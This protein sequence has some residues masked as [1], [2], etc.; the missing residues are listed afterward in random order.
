[1]DYYVKV[2]NLPVGDSA[3]ILSDNVPA[4]SFV[5][6]SS[7]RNAKSMYFAGYLQIVYLRKKVPAEFAKTL[8]PNRRNEVIQNYIKLTFDVPVSIYPNGN[9]YSGLDLMVAGYWAWS[10]KISTML[11]S[12]YSEGK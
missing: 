11:P 9:F 12:D 5:T 6:R 2:R 8:P 7:D 3:V 4:D 1:M 10:E